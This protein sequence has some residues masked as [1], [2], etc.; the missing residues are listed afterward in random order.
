LITADERIRFRRLRE[1]YVILRVLHNREF[2]RRY[3]GS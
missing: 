1:H 2:P 3:P